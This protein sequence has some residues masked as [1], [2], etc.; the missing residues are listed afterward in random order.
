M[1]FVANPPDFAPGAGDDVARCE[2]AIFG[3]VPLASEL[4]IVC[5]K[6]VLAAQECAIA[7]DWA[8]G[9]GHSAFDLGAPHVSMLTLP[10]DETVA[11]GEHVGRS[12]VAVFGWVPLAGDVWIAG[13]EIGLAG[14]WQTT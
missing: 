2:V 5:G 13:G 9:A 10:P 14:D 11:A 6:V 3:W 12:E 7:A 8:A 4:G 1:A